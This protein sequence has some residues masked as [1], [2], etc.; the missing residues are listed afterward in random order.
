MQILIIKKKTQY[1]A[2]LNLYIIKNTPTTTK[3][4]GKMPKMTPK[5]FQ[6]VEESSSSTT[7]SFRKGFKYLSS[8]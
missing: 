8:S 7:V 4:K 2:T 5:N 1:D 3:I 6:P